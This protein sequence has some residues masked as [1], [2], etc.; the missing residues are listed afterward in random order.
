MFLL[1][2][3]MFLLVFLFWLNT[4]HFLVGNQ[5]KL[6]D[7]YKIYKAD[8]HG[9]RKSFCHDV[10]AVLIAS[11]EEQ[12][13]GDIMWCYVTSGKN[14]HCTDWIAFSDV[15]YLIP[16]GHTLEMDKAAFIAS[17]SAFRILNPDRSYRK[18]RQDMLRLG[19][20]AEK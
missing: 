16:S 6:Y 7:V 4:L 19:K 2:F 18:W 12:Q 11:I 20:P 10:A 8:G 17:F 5:K 14:G 13:L 3:L 9:D 1:M 15:E